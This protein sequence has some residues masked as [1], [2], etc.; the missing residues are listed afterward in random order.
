MLLKIKSLLTFHR[1]KPH[2]LI[3]SQEQ[4]IKYNVPDMSCGHC[5]AS[6]EATIRTVDAQAEVNVDLTSKT[7]DITSSA[8]EADLIAA[9][10]GKGFP[11][12]PLPA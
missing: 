4:T 2:L 5:K 11:S 6:V 12:T 1:R 7:V 10:A 3:K 8:R 9:L